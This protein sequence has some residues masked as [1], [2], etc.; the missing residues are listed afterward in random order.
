MCTYNWQNQEL[1]TCLRFILA[2]TYTCTNIAL[3][4]FMP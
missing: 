2:L 1:C 3:L 4:L